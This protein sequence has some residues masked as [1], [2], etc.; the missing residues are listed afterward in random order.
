MLF[1]EECETWQH[2]LCCYSHGIAPPIHCCS[3]ACADQYLKRTR[4]TK[5]RK[6][7]SV[8]LSLTGTTQ[9]TMDSEAALEYNQTADRRSS[10]D[11][12]DEPLINKRIKVEARSVEDDRE[13]QTHAPQQRIEPD[14]ANVIDLTR[15]TGTKDRPHTKR[16]DPKPKQSQSSTRNAAPN[17][18]SYTKANSHLTTAS[19]TSAVASSPSRPIGIARG[20][21]PSIT[22]PL[23]PTMPAPTPTL[24]N[25]A[26][27][28]SPDRSGIENRSQHFTQCSTIGKLFGHAAAARTI[29]PPLDDATLPIEVRGTDTQLFVV[30]GDEEDFHNMMQMVQ[31]YGSCTVDVRAME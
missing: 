23:A 17:S 22:L 9:V 19:T 3:E 20:A 18:T 27:F 31:Q 28:V 2:T 6:S 1:C 7:Q 13:R 12:D 29:V 4:T 24:T 15:D 14:P 21:T 30:K 10:L 5:R 11:S 26:T 25:T 8:Q 16:E